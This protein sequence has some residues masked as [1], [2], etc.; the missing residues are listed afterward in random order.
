MYLSAG[1][2]SKEEIIKMEFSV[3]STLRWKLT[4]PNVGEMARILFNFF[5]EDPQ[6][7]SLAN[8]DETLDF[9]LSSN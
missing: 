9:C 6:P 4:E 8:I 5:V 2:Y 1:Q 7:Q 3:L